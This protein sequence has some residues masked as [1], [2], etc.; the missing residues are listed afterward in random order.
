MA[1]SKINNIAY[2]SLGKFKGVTKENLGKMANQSK[3]VV[4]GNSPYSK[5]MYLDDSNDGLYMYGVNSN[6][7]G[8]YVNSYASVAPFAAPMLDNTEPF[9]IDFEIRPH[10]SATSTL[11]KFIIGSYNTSTNGGLQVQLNMWG[12]N[13][14]VQVYWYR[15]TDSGGGGTT[16]G[17]YLRKT[18]Y[19]TGVKSN[20][21]TNCTVDGFWHKMTVCKGTGD[22]MDA[23]N[24]KVYMNGLEGSSVNTSNSGTWSTADGP[25]PEATWVPASNNQG[26]RWIQWVQNGS[27]LT[28]GSISWYNKML[29]STEVNE[30]YDGGARAGGSADQT[31]IMNI[32][33]RTASTSSNLL[34]YW[35]LDVS[36]DGQGGNTTYIVDKVSGGENPITRLANTTVSDVTSVTT[37]QLPLFETVKF[38]DANYAGESATFTASAAASGSTVRWYSDSGY[39][40]LLNTGTSYSFTIPSAGAQTLYLKDT[41]SGGVD[42]TQAVSYT[43]TATAGDLDYAYDM[44]NPSNMG[45]FNMHST[46]PSAATSIDHTHF[47][48]GKW[49]IGLWMNLDANHNFNGN[50]N[51]VSVTGL[52]SYGLNIHGNTTYPSCSI[53]I[54]NSYTYHHFTGGS[55]GSNIAS[56]AKGKWHHVIFSHDPTADSGNGTLTAW[57]NGV[58]C[59]TKTGVGTRLTD[60]DRDLQMYMHN[61]HGIIAQLAIY[62]DV[63]TDAEAIAIQGGA[64]ASGP[65]NS[66]DIANLSG[67]KDKLIDYWKFAEAHDNDSDDRLTSEDHS[68]NGA[69]YHQLTT[70]SSDNS[71]RRTNNRP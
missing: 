14:Y 24:F 44:N 19:F 28:V 36:A 23:S 70:G 49:S 69:L 68:S 59:G 62:G 45:F 39:S 71:A 40:S 32:D 43:S 30:I 27:P 20:H 31:K 41:S 33:P 56:W 53:G 22:S 50:M 67:S 11:N 55:L 12:T 3:P 26:Y 7:S 48:D 6:G 9:T 35:Y 66:Q 29:S 42:Q 47:T 52:W 21:F 61:S 5:S 38:Q 13:V 2:A 57:T 8:G 51:T 46:S 37:P 15:K 1:I 54:N 10:K 18:Y 63:L 65:G 25:I 34:H 58:N 64:G 4:L 17:G 16:D 60:T